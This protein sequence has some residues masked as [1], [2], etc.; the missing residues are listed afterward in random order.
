M[1]YRLSAAVVCLTVLGPFLQAASAQQNQ[2]IY[3][4]Y[5]GFYKNPDGSYTLSFAY[6]SHNADTVTIPP[7]PA[8][9]FAQAPADRM[10]PTVFLPGHWRFQCVMVV[11]PD[12]DG[13]MTWSLSY[14]GTTTGS[15]EKML[16][17]NWNLLEGAEEMKKIDYA[18]VPRG[19]C[20]NRPP[21]VRVLGLAPRRGLVPSLSVGVNEELNLFGSAH[22]EGLPRG[23][24]FVAGWKVLNGPGT[25]T[26]SNPTSARTKAT[27]SAAGTYE[28]ELT[29]SDSEFTERYRLNV[30]VGGGF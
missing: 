25:A 30:K 13:R 21:T 4:V 20:L 1:S 2:P 28:L 14:A 15:S 8:N 24:A 17:S 16:Q 11:G 10:Q 3:P 7:G 9:Q 5:D 29:A 23:K 6:F 12:F 19:V 22:D 26:F 27:F 18:K